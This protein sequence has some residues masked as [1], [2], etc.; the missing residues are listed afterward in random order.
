[1][2]IFL[3]LFTVFS[4]LV[5]S[6]IDAEEEMTVSLSTES[7][8]VPLYLSPLVDQQD[9][10]DPAYLKQLEN[11]LFFDLNR[12]GKTTV[13]K[14]THANN[15]ELL[16]GPYEEMGHP[17]YWKEQHIFYVVKVRVKNNALS[18]LLLNIDD[19][20]LKSIDPIPLTGQLNQDRKQIHRLADAIHKALFGIDGI[21]STRI[22]YTLKTSTMPGKSICDVWESDYDGAN[23]HPVTKEGSYCVTPVYIPPKPGFTTGGVVYVSYQIGQPKLYAASSKDGIGRRLVQL[24]GNQLMPAISRQRDKLAFISDVTG[25]PDLF[26]QPF[27]P[28]EGAIGKPQQIFSAKQATQG[29]PAFDPEGKTIAFVSDKDGSPRIYTIDIPAP[30]TSLK[31]IRARLITKRNRENTAPSWSPDGTKLAYCARH[32]GSDRQIWIYDFTTN[33][34]KQIT[35]GPGHKENPSWAPNSLHL[36]FNT[37]DVNSADLFLID[38][39]GAEAVKITAGPGEKRFPNWEPRL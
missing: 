2:K 26:L 24:R 33:E 32:A 36:V 18:A 1:M 11:V 4:F 7:S 17:S 22:L 27:S 34:E 39:N 12:N 19:N 3:Y 30:G 23:A 21:A 35:K 8:L 10:Y 13:T 38:L 29:S 16:L 14:Q 37:A 20:V 28:E 25:N 15:Q 5:I 31:N 6:F 9:F